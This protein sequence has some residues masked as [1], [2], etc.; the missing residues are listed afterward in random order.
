MTSDWNPSLQ[1]VATLG[2]AWELIRSVP[3]QVSARWVFYQLLQEGY[4]SKKKDYKN[5][6]IKASSRAR[7]GFYKE[8]TPYTLADETRESIYRGGGYVDVSDWLYSLSQDATCVLDKWLDQDYYVE[9]WYEA[10][11]MSQQF[12]YYTD[13]MTLVPMAGQP[14]IPFKWQIAKDLESNS[15]KYDVPIIIL[16]FGDLDPAGEVIS[17]VVEREVRE[18][19]IADFEFIRCGLTPE[20]VQQYNVPENP[21]KPDEYQWEA[22]SDEGAQEII[23]GYVDRYV[24]HGA[25]TEIEKLENKA[26]EYVRKELKD[27]SDSWNNNS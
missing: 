10:R 3:Y 9:L 24:R 20:Q 16:Y 17:D 15:R 23:T 2:R 6:W 4:Y 12:R 18:W 14:S 21:D 8:W 13:H 1:T 25:F 7:K 27:L 19:S 22:L 26:E 11:A 5:K